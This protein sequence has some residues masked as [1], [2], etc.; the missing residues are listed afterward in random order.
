MSKI[1]SVGII[2]FKIRSSMDFCFLTLY[3]QQRK[4]DCKPA[5]KMPTVKCCLSVIFFKIP[6]R[7][8]KVS[9]GKWTYLKFKILKINVDC[10]PQKKQNKTKQKKTSKVSKQESQLDAYPVGDARDVKHV[11]SLYII[12]KQNKTCYSCCCLPHGCTL[13]RQTASSVW[14][15]S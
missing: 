9:N 10:M 13:H 12:N 14:F 15:R 11:L 5:G 8:S 1:Y 7:N 3:S 2:F 6:I 4:D